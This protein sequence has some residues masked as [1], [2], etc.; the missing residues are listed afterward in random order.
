MP[1]K[2]VYSSSESESYSD[3]ETLSE[4]YSDSDSDYSEDPYSS[5]ERIV[6]ELIKKYKR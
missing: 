6:D 5:E 2:Q 1:R 3:S 4:S